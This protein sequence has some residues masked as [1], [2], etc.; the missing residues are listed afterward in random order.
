[1]DAV[2]DAMPPQVLIGLVT[3]IIVVLTRLR[4]RRARPRRLMIVPGVVTLV[5]AFLLV[6]WLGVA[7]TGDLVATIS[8][9]V[10]DLAFTV[11]LGI[12]RGL[13]VEV[14]TDS[15]GAVRYRYTWLTVLLWV[16]AVALRFELAEVG[17]RWGASPAVTEG[18]V[19][20]ALGIA[21]LVQNL[22]VIRLVGRL[23]RSPETAARAASASSEH[24]GK[25][26]EDERGDGRA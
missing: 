17:A 22:V 8:V 12:A 15:A 6:P 7:A 10:L 11:A 23:R 26:G 19:L 20:L 3:L 18:S 13:T 1:M 21:L 2:L 4:A 14:R 16:V 24:Q 25:G 5:G 9:A